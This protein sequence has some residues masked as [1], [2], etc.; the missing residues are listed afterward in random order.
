[1]FYIY[2]IYNLLFNSKIGLLFYLSENVFLIIFY[3]L[4]FF[5]KAIRFK[6]YKNNKRVVETTTLVKLKINTFYVDFILI[7]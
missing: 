7:W 3:L 4:V 1:M 5:T 2:T 6:Y